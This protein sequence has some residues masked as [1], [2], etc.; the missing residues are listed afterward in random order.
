MARA[1]ATPPR[2]YHSLAHVVEVAQRFAEVR[3]ERPNEAYAAVLF[4]DA[5][6]EPG[7]KDN[8][9]RSAA[10]ARA[11]LAGQPVDVE[12]VA[13]LILL[14]AR[15]GQLGPGDVDADAA[16]FLDCDLAILGS[17]PERFDAYDAAIAQEH[18]HL[19][20]EAYAQGR[21]AFLERMLARERLFLSPHFHAALEARARDNLRRAL[22]R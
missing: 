12:R 10:L 18:A 15:H 22:E 2:A 11:S 1:H 19:P 3:F 14:T 16:L 8:E 9:A 7:R 13:E 21:R 20:P 5:I 17:P 6:Y 4:H